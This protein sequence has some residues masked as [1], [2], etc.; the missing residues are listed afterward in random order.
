[1]AVDSRIQV[2]HRPGVVPV[3]ADVEAPTI[4]IV[5]FPARPATITVV[6]PTLNEERNIKWVLD[7]IPPIV[8]EVLLVDGRSTDLTVGIAQAVRPD[9][10]VVHEDRP[11]KGVALRTAF[12]VATGD[13]I[14]MLDADCSM[15]PQDIEHYVDAIM[16][17]ADLVKG[18]RNLPGGG[19]TDISRLRQLGN[20]S[21]LRITN[22]LYRTSFSELCY[23]YM[24]FRRDR[25]P[26]LALK[27]T[28]F[29][30][31]T[32]IVTRSIRAGLRIDEVPSFE[33]ERRYGTSH[34]NTFRDGWRVLKTLLRERFVANV[35]AGARQDVGAP[36]SIQEPKRPQE[37]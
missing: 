12:A 27:S 5:P 23:G 8:D 28:G 7:R 11:G 13:I 2:D 37:S 21:L 15:D 29:E 6:I 32:E 9:I 36:L 22:L 18:S 4:A 35:K 33:S 14:V 34:L 26:D 31:E 19:S 20:S 24:A 30:I 1:M 16:D 25:L 3:D 17:G 10:V